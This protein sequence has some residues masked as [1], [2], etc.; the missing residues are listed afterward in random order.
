MAG[1][2]WQ[3]LLAVHCRHRESK[4]GGGVDLA[5]GKAVVAGLGIPVVI[6]GKPAL[7]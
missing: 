7:L 3:G 1:C 2:I 6:N 4:H 5:T